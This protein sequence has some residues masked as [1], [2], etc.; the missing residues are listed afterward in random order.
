MD[1]VAYRENG[2]QM[3][4]SFDMH[5]AEGEILGLLPLNSYGLTSLLDVMTQNPPL[6]YGFVFYREKRINSWR[7]PRPRR[8]PIGLIYNKS[9]LANGLSLADN[10]FVLREGF[11]AWYIRPKLLQS[12]LRLLFREIGV[13]IPIDTYPENLSHFQR[14]VVELLR[15]KVAGYRLIVLHD[16]A[17]LLDEAEL[18]QL[19][20]IIRHCAREGMSFLYIGFRPEELT[21][22]CDRISIFSNGRILQTADTPDALGQILDCFTADEQHNEGAQAMALQ[23]NAVL[24]AVGL[25]RGKAEGL[26]FSVYPDECVVL[27]DP[28]NRADLL[29]DILSGEPTPTDGKLLLYGKPITG[30]A[31]RDIAVIQESPSQSMIFPKLSYF[32]N[33][34]LCCDHQLPQLW[35]NPQMQRRLAREYAQRNHDAELFQ[36]PVEALTEMEKYDLV[37]NRILLQ[38]PKV[39][40]CVRP[41]KSAD[42]ELREHILQL[43]EQLRKKQIAVVI[44]TANASACIPVANRVVSILGA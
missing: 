31:N 11:R 16:A 17:A 18:E 39:A 40:I 23:G 26:D 43:I 13:D 36:Q 42:I 15:A 44:S 21:A 8:N 10:V 14:I 29:V 41:F 9:Q 25:S 35:R 22:I 27:L 33:L 5:I 2:V 4:T 7:D 20:R 32:D 19:R 12:Q 1:R 6:Q 30:Q 28:H 3:L 38:K 24:Q 37:Y 34:F